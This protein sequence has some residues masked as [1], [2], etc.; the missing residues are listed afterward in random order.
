MAG[1]AVDSPFRAGGAGGAG[2]YGEGGAGGAGMARG[3][4]VAGKAGSRGQEAPELNEQTPADRPAS[5]SQT[6][7]AQQPSEPAAEELGEPLAEPSSSAKPLAPVPSEPPALKT[8]ASEMKSRAL[9]IEKAGALDAI[10]PADPS[11]EPMDSLKT[12]D[13]L[14]APDSPNGVDS[15]NALEGSEPRSS[16]FR[17][18]N[19]WLKEKETPLD[20]DQ[21]PRVA[22]DRFK[23]RAVYREYASSGLTTWG[24]QT[25][26]P[27]EETVLWEPLL[28]PD[29]NG[30]AQ[31]QFSLPDRETTYRILV[32]GDLG[33]R[34]GSYRNQVV[35]KQPNID[36]PVEIA[37]PQQ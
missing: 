28:I 36:L 32:N 26:T 29:E 5:G 4:R 25:Q 23:R 34:I 12:P 22:A 19:E 8:M 16:F 21:P 3:A 17:Q 2:G 20:D 18:K 33:G 13:S 31:L 11:V 10:V 15:P 9:G 27:P 37:D 1:Q 14:N 6:M 24:L 35:A 7:R 30:Q